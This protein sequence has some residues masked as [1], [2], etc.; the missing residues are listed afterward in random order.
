MISRQYIHLIKYILIEI[1]V[2]FII[3][4]DLID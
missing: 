1:I 4:M 2:F 3:L